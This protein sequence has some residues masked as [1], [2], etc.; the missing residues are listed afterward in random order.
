[1]TTLVNNL[2]GALG[3][4]DQVL[5]RGSDVSEPGIVA[6]DIFGAQGLNF[7]G[8]TYQYI[9]IN[10][11]GNI[12]LSNSSTAS[13]STFTPFDLA[14]SG[15]AIIAPFFADV[16][17]SHGANENDNVV[18]YQ[19]DPADNGILTVTWHDVGYF[20]GHTDKANSFQLQLIGA[21][22]GN[23]DI[24]FRYESI[25][26]T[27]GDD[28]LGSSGLGG[29][30]ARAGFSSGAGES[31]TYY[32]LPQSGLQNSM[33]GLG[34]TL[35]N[36][37]TAGYYKFS[38]RCGTDDA[39]ILTGTAADDV[40]VG[41]G[42]D[43]TLD[44][45]DGNDMLYG[46]GKDTMLGGKGNDTY[47]V[48]GFETI[49]E[50][51]NEGVDTVVSKGSYSLESRKF[52][53]NL[54]L[55]GAQNSTGR[56]NSLDNIL[57]G[58]AGNNILNGLAGND[59]IDYSLAT[60]AV[61]VNL[62][63]T[64][65][66]HISS[67]QG[68]DT[69]L[70]I[71]GIIG[72]DADDTLTGNGSANTINGG[73]GADTIAGGDGDDI[74]IGGSGDDWLRGE[75]GNDI[76]IGGAGNDTLGGGAGSDT[77]SYVDATGAVTVSLQIEVAQNTVS[78]GVDS[79]WNIENLTGSNYDDT[80]TG[81]DIN[82]QTGKT[83]AN[84]L[85]GGS[86]ADRMIGGSGDDIYYVDNVGD[87]VIEDNEVG[88][89][90]V[91]STISYTLGNYVENLRI[92]GT[93][94]VNG[95]GNDLDNILYAGNGNNVLD[96]GKGIDTASY[97]DANAAVTVSLA[98]TDGQDTGGSGTDTLKSIENLTG[99]RFYDTLT[100]DG[101]GNIVNGGAGA[102]TMTGG[103]G[104]DTYI[105]DNAGDR[106]IEASTIATEV[107][108]VISTVTWTLGANLENLTLAGAT[109]INGTGN[110]LN[111]HI[112][113]NNAANIINGGG[114]ADV[115]EG[116]NGS[117]TYYVDNPGDVVK[118]TNAASAG[119]VDTVR[120][121]INYTLGDNVENLV[122][123]GAGAVNGTG[124]ALNNLIYAG[125]G[126]NIIDGKGGADTVSYA[127]AGSKVT[128]S[129]ANTKAQATGG[130]GTD[131]I[132]NIESCVGSIFN[133]I[134]TGNDLDNILNGGLG[135][136]T[137]SGGKG[138]D[139][140]IG[141]N[142]NDTLIGGAG[143]D[144]LTGGLGADVFRFDALADTGLTSGTWDIITDFNYAQHDIIDLS[145]IDAN[146]LKTGDQAFAF[147]GTAAFSSTDATGQLRFDAATH[148][149]Y[150]STD[151]DSA[152]E[153]AIQLTG[154]VSLVGTN[155]KL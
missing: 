9:S 86:G 132:I 125:A 51:I 29:T 48:S 26:W 113:G 21:G 142:G 120:S 111:N 18:W 146:E 116:G 65:S 72:S 121:T 31:S 11:N 105:V 23:F 118:E 153:F 59:T 77:A 106:I 57:R 64:A 63:L 128:V 89:D 143:K 17:T 2:G 144:T 123:A 80:L 43:D 38:V 20:S 139:T 40:L 135:N 12:T 102:D 4:G 88:D 138:A 6:T 119:G 148:I 95:T 60:S 133:D 152:A 27:T 41:L 141:G 52:I 71:E 68:D 94:T 147:I 136:D 91:Y 81:S 110:A 24:I 151:K 100:G 53:E 129:L 130:S 127:L 73:R 137:L 134:L 115:M 33:L 36:T 74:L 42:G 101:K 19:Y 92:I 93:G 131:T 107:D 66:Q 1:M 28:S 49:I 124:N 67:D 46:N 50:Y 76:L 16:D 69:L 122:I 149:L 39:D 61:T 30:V 8:T 58:N 85:N 155:F 78:A 55:T 37:G 32:E 154:V 114:G 44:G 34:A 5:L 103:L 56:G 112:L 108:T 35:G 90:T 82:I 99:S 10:D 140:L 75:A 22:D 47:F 150:G 70:N 84:V 145:R 104:N 62:G 15:T 117:D 79:L 87:T 96:G 126:D 45:G 14:T 7:F 13:L 98:V 3:F 54:F 97:A 83:G 109:A 25:Q